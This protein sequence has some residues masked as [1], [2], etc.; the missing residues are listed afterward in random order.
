VTTTAIGPDDS[1]SFSALTDYLQSV[2]GGDPGSGG[3]SSD[4]ASASG[5]DTVFD[6][7]SDGGSGGGIPHPSTDGT[8][9][10]AAGSGTTFIQFTDTTTTIS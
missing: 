3:G 5:G 1:S 6:T 10:I 9:D 8:S 7:N 2:G 4:T